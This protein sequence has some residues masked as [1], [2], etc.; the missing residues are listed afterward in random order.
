VLL[1]IS[2]LNRIKQQSVYRVSRHPTAYSLAS[3]HCAVA[4]H[5]QYANIS[6]STLPRQISITSIGT[7]WRPCGAKT[8]QWTHG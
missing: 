6:R 5:D 8:S 3:F 4:L 1:V 2:Y 7:M